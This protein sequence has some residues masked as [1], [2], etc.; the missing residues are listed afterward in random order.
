MVEERYKVML[1]F[2]WCTLTAE[3]V[4]ATLSLSLQD[5]KYKQMCRKNDTA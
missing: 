1:I 2:N 5:W 3:A 4:Y